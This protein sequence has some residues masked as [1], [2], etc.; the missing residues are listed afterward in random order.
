MSKLIEMNNHG[1]AFAI[2]FTATFRVPD[3]VDCEA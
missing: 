3:F 2:C 1:N